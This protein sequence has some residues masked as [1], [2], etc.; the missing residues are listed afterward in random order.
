MR[1]ANHDTDERVL[2]IAEI[3]NNHEGDFGR[4]RE[5]VHAAAE[6]GA[7]AVKFQTFR[8]GHYV[9]PAD[10]KRTAMLQGFELTWDQFAALRQEA[11]GAGVL[12]LSTPFDIASARF[13]DGIVP[14]FKIASGDNTFHPLLEAVARCHKPVLLSCGLASLNQLAFAR[15]LVQRIWDEACVDPGMA[16]LHCVTSYPVPEAEANLAAIAAIAEAT[17]CTPGYSDHTLGIR[18]AV[19]SVAAGARIVE[20]HFT[21][22]KQLSD[23]RD[24]QLSADPD[25]LAGLVRDIRQAETLLGSGE[26]ALARCEE[27]VREAVRRSIAA[28]RDLPQGHVLAWDDLTWVRP[29]GGFAPGDET[30]VLGRR[31]A[32]ALPMGSP[33]QPEDLED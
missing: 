1:I 17:G 8:T 6:A 21:L 16:A 24:H 27:P 19:L 5:M 13:L 14:A 33:L 7:D 15:A 26:K 3:G 10:P 18:A 28:G 30:S 11:D 4:A 9:S 23:F 22:D 31:L 29:G 2:V 25:E 12:F 20:K 32:R